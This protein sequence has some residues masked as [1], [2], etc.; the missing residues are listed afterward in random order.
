MRWVLL[1]ELEYG[2]AERPDV[3]LLVV[4]TLGD[5]LG[6][7]PQRRADHRAAL[8][9]GPQLGRDAQVAEL[10]GAIAREQNVA[11]L[12]VAVDEAECVVQVLERAQRRAADQPDLRLGQRGAAHEHGVEGRAVRPL[13]RNPDHALIWLLVGALK[14][15]DEGRGAHPQRLN[16]AVERVDRG[17]VVAHVEQFHRHLPPV[18]AAG[19]VVDRAV[20]TASYV[21]LYDEHSLRIALGDH[22]R[23]AHSVSLRLLAAAAPLELDCTPSSTAAAAHL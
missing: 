3:R 21:R 13:H 11:A 14:G 16:L 5:Q 1:G 10:A 20:G 22:R 19:C 17:L 4:L 9:A 23:A 2:D 8:A 12:H 6:A 7:H 18:G 15:H